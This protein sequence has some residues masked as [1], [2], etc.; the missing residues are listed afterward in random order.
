MPNS[1][2]S[3][4]KS[5]KLKRIL[6]WF[7]SVLIIV[8][9]GLGFLLTSNQPTDDLFIRLDEFAYF[10]EEGESTLVTFEASPRLGS[11]NY[12][13][14]NSDVVQFIENRLIAV[15]PGNATI[16]VSSKSNPSVFQTV[17][18][19]VRPKDLEPEAPLEPEVPS[20][21]EPEVPVDVEPELP[22]D[23]EPEVPVNPVD[24]DDSED[25]GVITPP[26]IYTITITNETGAVITTLEVE[27]GSFITTS[28]LELP[29][30]FKG[31]F[32]EGETCSDDPFDLETPITENLTLIQASFNDQA[33]CL[34]LDYIVLSGRPVA[35]TTLTV[36]VFPIGANVTISWYTSVN[37]RIYREIP[38]E[39]G[40]AFTVRPE[41]SG[42]FIRVYVVSDS[43]PP[44]VRFDTIKLDV[45]GTVSEID[46]RIP[47]TQE[48]QASAS[49]I[50]AAGSIPIAYPEDLE[51]IGDSPEALSRSYVL[52]RDIDL[53][54]YQTLDNSFI[55]GTFSGN[56]SGQGFTISNLTINAPSSNEVGLFKNISGAF[57]ENLII[58]SFNVTGDFATGSLIGKIIGGHN[59]VSSIT[60]TNSSISGDGAV[61]GLIGE[62][63][64]DALTI[65]N[66]TNYATVSSTG[67]RTGGILGRSVN[68]V[69]ISRVLNYG[70]V[71][72]SSGYTGGIAGRFE[73]NSI[74]TI[75]EAGNFGLISSVG[76]DA[77]GLVG[78]TTGNSSPVNQMI[79]ENSFNVGT[80]EITGSF[81]NS[82]GILGFSDNSIITLSS[83]YSAGNVTTAGFRAGLI[84]G[85]I[86]NTTLAT[87]AGIFS[88]N[89]LDVQVDGYTSGTGNNAPTSAFSTKIP[90]VN[91]VLPA[92]FINAGW[93][94]TDASVN[95]TTWSIGFNGSY[96]YPY[97]TFQGSPN[98][99]Q[100]VELN[101][102]DLQIISTIEKINNEGYVPI[103]SL[104][105][106][107]RIQTIQSI[108][109]KFAV[110]TV[111][112]INITTSGLSDRYILVTNVALDTA[113][114]NSIIDGN[115]SGIFDGNNYV[116][117]GF[118]VDV[119]SH[120]Y[121]GLFRRLSGEANISNITLD[122][123]NFSG[124][125]ITNSVD[126]YGF[127]ASQ[128]QVGNIILDT[129]LITN[130]SMQIDFVNSSFNYIGGVIGHIDSSS[131]LKNITISS[132]EIHNVNFGFK[133]TSSSIFSG[134]LV[135]YLGQATR[136]I[137]LN[138]LT[139]SG[140]IEYTNQ[141]NGTAS[142]NQVNIGGII[143]QIYNI[144][145]NVNLR[146]NLIANNL[147]TNNILKINDSF[148]TLQVGGFSGS[149]RFT[150]D[151]MK[152]TINNSYF[153]DDIYFSSR[154]TT[155]GDVNVGGLIGDSTNIITISSVTVESNI[156][157]SGTST[158]TSYIGGFIGHANQPS[159][160]IYLLNSTSSSIISY[161]GPENTVNLYAVGGFI[162]QFDDKLL[163]GYG[164]HFDGEISVPSSRARH[165]LELRAVTTYIVDLDKVSVDSSTSLRIVGGR[166]GLRL[167]VDGVL[168]AD[169]T[170]FTEQSNVRI[171]YP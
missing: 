63:V 23:P 120:S 95:T 150:S 133:V 136:D 105:D 124:N 3:K 27:E 75:S 154:T 76:S 99:L 13:S 129:I 40:S 30:L 117:S 145:S 74:V 78:G 110:G 108:A 54:D 116:L 9:S 132:L 67:S 160:S 20:Q 60:I 68:E 122:N 33:P 141:S 134:L 143:G 70:L 56:L 51:A 39:S 171:L 37:N 149:T 159:S 111:F 162:G 157:I 24:P 155:A 44:V 15:S 168:T 69:N 35:G 6:I 147:T 152:V 131:N 48:E 92:T 19:I 86:E 16:M 62:N 36:D 31:F 5:S 93:N 161:S 2:F 170:E 43:N 81:N 84:F 167:F 94:I 139:I 144:G 106:L 65:N 46:N 12:F 103:S 127:I 85:R 10:I 59:T 118:T 97:L 146:L 61:G 135:G 49:A 100:Q 42:K 142:D 153:N 41:D 119:S 4:R 102:N 101:Q 158:S 11:F 22:E 156:S 121:A 126:Y 114:S 87:Q 45:F 18:V 26:S 50:I 32:L 14:N 17:S 104:L 64:G 47:L 113:Q 7:F 77:G 29:E 130:S 112:E 91:M 21:P 98:S 71:T 83:I 52:I 90:V 66:V 82:A 151:P 34:Q 138:N 165:I 166:T 73:G 55:N 148:A 96:T 79:I 38:G 140:M 115:F 28:S 58:D 128:V 163:T 8:T 25:D 88:L 125:R 80:V 89:T 1:S 164:I 123:F 53:T 109:T 169:T 57:I 72:S 137:I 107:Q